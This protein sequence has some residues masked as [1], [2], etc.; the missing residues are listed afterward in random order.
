MYEDTTKM[1]TLAIDLAK[2]VFQVA[3]E[4]AREKVVFEARYPSRA[5]FGEFLHTLQPPLAVLME[6]GPGAQAWARELQAHG[7]TVRVLPAQRVAEH[8]SGAKN[9]RKDAHALLRAG[10]DRSIAA[11]PVKSVERLTMQALR[12]Q[13]RIQGPRLALCGLNPHA[14]EETRCGREEEAVFLPVLRAL[15][16]QGMI[17]DGPFAADGFFARH[18]ERDY[19]AILC[20]YHDQGLIPFKMLARDQGCQLSVG[21]PVVRTSPDH[22]SA[23]DIAG[24]GIADP[25]SM[26]YAL[27][28]AATLALRAAGHADSV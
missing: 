22:G 28:L 20:P 13:F 27:Q 18:P 6:T 24:R 1:T 23:L 11:V 8:R 9:D 2:D 10:R 7:V 4:D 14:G 17:C 5:A 26:R 12:Q 3:G 25:G 19:D 15:R 21:L 16:R